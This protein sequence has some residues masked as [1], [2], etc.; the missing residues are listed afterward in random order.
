[1]NDAKSHWDVWTL[2]AY[3]LWL[4]FFLFGFH[5]EAV[6]QLARAA[7][8][9]ATQSAIVNSPH[10]ITLALAGYLGYFAY[11]RCL[12]VG[13]ERP[14][15]KAR[16]LQFSILG[17]IAF[18]TF[19]PF[20]LLALGEIPVRQYQMIVL[21]VG[22]TK[23]FTWFLLLSVIMRYYLLGHLQ[24]FANMASMFPSTYQSETKG[25]GSQAT[26]VTWIEGTQD[27]DTAPKLTQTDAGT[28]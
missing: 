17:L 10:V 5:P 24:V 14:D 4:I 13:M 8:L 20:S 26:S 7:G 15:A 3:A 16:G 22:G 9:V 25:P 18:L 21:F 23:L 6:F 1:M 12:D 28:K 19:S 11:Q 27:H 2:P